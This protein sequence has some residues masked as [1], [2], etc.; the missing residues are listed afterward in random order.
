MDGWGPLFNE[1]GFSGGE[2]AL[3]GGDDFCAATS[4]D[5]GHALLISGELSL[6]ASVIAGLLEISVALSPGGVRHLSGGLAHR[7]IHK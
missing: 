1:S 4:A 5:H 6:E 7:S 2:R 3:C